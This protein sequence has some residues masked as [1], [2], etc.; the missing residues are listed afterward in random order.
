MFNGVLNKLV[1]PEPFDSVRPELVE[2]T[3]GAQESPVEGQS[4]V[5]R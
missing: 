1:R 3:N 5:S 4:M 2:G